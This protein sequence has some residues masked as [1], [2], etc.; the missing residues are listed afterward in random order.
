MLR[1]LNLQEQEIFNALKEVFDPEL[2]VNI[3]D[4]GLVYDA[5]LNEAE[6]SIEIDLTLTSPGCPLGDVIIGDVYQL[7]S[8]KF[9][10][11]QSTVNL[12]W[13]PVWTPERLTVEGRKALGRN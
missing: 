11:H 3:V 4:L 13:E 5:K 2:M 8:V 7:L 10:N 1:D 9:P 12:V 6:E